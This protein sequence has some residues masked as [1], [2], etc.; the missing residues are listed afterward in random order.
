LAGRE[1][2]LLVLDEIRLA[3]LPMTFDDT[4]ARRHLGYASRP[5]ATALAAAARA[6]I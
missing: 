2:E 1:P 5:A 3:R 4:K 6:Y